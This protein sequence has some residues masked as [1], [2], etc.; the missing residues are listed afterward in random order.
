MLRSIQVLLASYSSYYNRKYAR[1]GPL[2]ES[3]YRASFIDP[4]PYLQHVSKYIHLNPVHWSAHPYS[5]L[6]RLDDN[7]KA[8][9]DWLDTS[10]LKSEFFSKHGYMDFL[11][12]DSNDILHNKIGFY[13]I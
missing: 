11:M 7:L 12:Q 6:S 4:L 13:D 2:F 3:R 9:V 10:K 5:S 8:T 1:R